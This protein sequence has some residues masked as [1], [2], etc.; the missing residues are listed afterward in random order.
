MSCLGRVLVCDRG[1]QR[2]HAISFQTGRTNKINFSS[3]LSGI[4]VLENEKMLVSFNDGTIRQIDGTGKEII[5]CNPFENAPFRTKRM[6]DNKTD[7]KSFKFTV[8][9]QD[10]VYVSNRIAS[11]I[12]KFH[13]NENYLQTLHLKMDNSLCCVPTAICSGQLETLIV[14][15]GIN[16]MVCSFRRSDGFLDGM[17]L[18]PSDDVGAIESVALTLEGHIADTEFA[19]NGPHCIKIF[20][21]L[22]CACHNAPSEESTFADVRQ[23]DSRET[24]S[25][26]Q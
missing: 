5:R 18:K 6:T 17:L 3:A 8:D 13:C 22:H 16:H 12:K 1:N 15:D 24:E 14:A 11:Q 7:N 19:A 23:V 20:R 10:I 21:Y 9:E 26:D 4:Q 2:L 25:I